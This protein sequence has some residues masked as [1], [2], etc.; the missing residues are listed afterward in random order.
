MIQA[1]LDKTS[2]EFYTG[3]VPVCLFLNS[4]LRLLFGRLKHVIAKS[5]VDSSLILI[6]IGRLETSL[7]T[8]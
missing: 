6:L 8:D 1:L 2:C 4:R 5:L 7:E 3:S